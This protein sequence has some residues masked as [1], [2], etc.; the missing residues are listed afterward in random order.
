M[1]KIN[2]LKDEPYILAAL[3]VKISQSPFEKTLDE[4]YQE[5]KENKEESKKLVNSIIKKHHHNIL[6]DF[7]SCAV[8][9]EGI[10]RLAILYLWR[11]I[12]APNLIPGAGIEA[13]LRV[14]KPTKYN[15]LVRDFGKQ[16]FDLYERILEE[17][18]PGQDARYVIPEGALTRVIFAISPRYLLKLR[19][20]LK[21]SPLE[22]LKEIGAGFEKIVRE[23]GFETEIEEVPATF[24]EIW[25]KETEDNK[26]ES[27]LIFSGEPTTLSLDY[28]IN[29]SLSMYAQLV[30][31][32]QF[33]IELEPAE[34][35]A[36]KARFVVPNSFS[37]KIKKEYIRL[38]KA[39]NEKQ[40]ELIEK[41]DPKFVYFLLLGQEAKSRVSGKGKGILETSKKR[42]CGVAQ[43]E[44]RSNVAVPI[45]RKLAK[46][47][48]LKNEIG[49]RCWREGRCIE[50]ATFKTKNSKCPVFE[51]YFGKRAES[52]ESLLELLNQPASTIKVK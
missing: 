29:G 11:N 10:S 31:D 15:E 52:F 44:L 7:T 9:I 48:E 40:L 24:W 43:W 1:V 36:K 22:E 49:P 5:C 33:L 38:A 17:E 13:S 45:T 34:R 16:A 51:K 37:N 3:G 12:N 18:V 21:N 6:L 8:T 25:D 27:S 19:N 50:P 30:R 20:I 32:R 23:I 46:Y 41:K 14:I 39:A 42:C 47:T 26:N 28:N 2:Y 4:L 35:I